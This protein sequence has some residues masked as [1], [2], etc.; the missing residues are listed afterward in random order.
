MEYM[1]MCV[2]C[3]GLSTILEKIDR[4]NAVCWTDRSA[5]NTTIISFIKLLDQRFHFTLKW[6]LMIT[7]PW[8]ME[9]WTVHEKKAIQIVNMEAMRL[10]VWGG[11]F[12]RIDREKIVHSICINKNTHTYTH[13]IVSTYAFCILVQ[14]WM[15]NCA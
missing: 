7:I 8:I 4:V 2:L 1:D 5:T 12:R 3:V 15:I 14:Y 11:H 9:V 10:N 6:H 13:D